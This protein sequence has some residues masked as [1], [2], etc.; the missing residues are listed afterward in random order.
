MQQ[1]KEPQ[2]V[3]GNIGELGEGRSHDLHKEPEVVSLL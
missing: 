1:S 2:D 3:S